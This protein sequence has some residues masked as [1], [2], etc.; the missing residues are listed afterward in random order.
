MA[1]QKYMITNEVALAAWRRE[2]MT[3]RVYSIFKMYILFIQYI[4]K[5]LSFLL[6][7]TYRVLLI[8]YILPYSPIETK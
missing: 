2:E 6:S 4:L 5:F 3:W 8:R 7:Q 1:F